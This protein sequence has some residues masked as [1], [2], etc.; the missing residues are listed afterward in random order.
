[1]QSSETRVRPL[2]AAQLRRRFDD[3]EPDFQ[4]TATLEDLHT[5][6][7]ESICVERR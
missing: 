2:G 5:G 4:T 1:M 6:R 3:L 7:F